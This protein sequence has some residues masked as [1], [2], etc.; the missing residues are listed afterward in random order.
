MK[1]L[2]TETFESKQAN[3]CHCNY[4]IM[5]DKRKTKQTESLP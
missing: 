4:F 5:A 1:K 3:N 2:N